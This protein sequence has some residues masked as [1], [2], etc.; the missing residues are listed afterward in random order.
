MKVVTLLLALSIGGPQSAQVDQP[1]ATRPE[2]RKSF[3][4]PAVEIVLL[5]SVINAFGR[6]AYED[7]SFDV[8]PASI[9]RNLHTPWVV[10]DDPFQVNQVLHPY[11]GAMYHSAARS[12]GL[13]YW[14]S[15]AYTF[16]GSA[17]WE[18]AGETTPPSVNDQIA[19]G[20]AGSFLGEALFRTANLLIDK[21]GGDVGVGR[22]LLVLLLSPPTGVNRAVFGD[23]FDGVFPTRD[24]A[25]DVRVH[26]GAESPLQWVEQPG[27]DRRYD[28]VIDLFMEY[29]VPGK[30]GYHYGRPFDLFSLQATATSANLQSLATRGL[31]AGGRYDAGKDGGGAWGLFGSFDYFA[32]R[33]FR[34]SSTALSFGTT[35]QAWA[36]HGM[37]VQA[38]T[39]IGVGYVAAQTVN[40]ATDRDYRYG[41]APQALASLRVIGGD[42]LSIDLN[43]RPFVVSNVAG[44]DQHGRDLI[45]LGD[46][47]V[48]LRLY[49][50]NA[51]TVRYQLSRRTASLPGSRTVVQQRETIGVFYTLVGPQRFGA[52]RKQ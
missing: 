4:T 12:A 3:L 40:G 2:I 18:I 17:L 8:T 38:T 19:S 20:I 29:G 28:A 32:P 42:R 49:R 25:Y 9:R 16:A 14:Q 13:N 39:T 41:L 47:S 34:V 50:R 46:A 31:L 21:S 1:D 26:F 22:G 51:L 23:R 52:L 33:I 15:A 30:P 44:F 48:G 45:L 7:G 36:S 6:R 11:Q 24:P 43:A 37:A 5:D 35:V 27:A 10:D